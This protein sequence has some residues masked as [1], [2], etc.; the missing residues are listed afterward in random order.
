MSALTTMRD[1]VIPVKTLMVLT[2]VTV[3]MGLS[4]YQTIIHV[5][6]SDNTQGYV[7]I[8]YMLLFIPSIPIY[9]YAYN[10]CF[11]CIDVC[12]IEK[13]CFYMVCSSYVHTY[14]GNFLKT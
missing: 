10:L 1:V 8:V 4:C 12:T 9:M 5:K 14:L 2:I 7:Q 3:L 13:K 11:K 6:V